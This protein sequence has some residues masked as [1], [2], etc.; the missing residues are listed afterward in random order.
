V[1]K[2]W[3]F[4]VGALAVLAACGGGGSEETAR[5]ETPA[6]VA[7]AGH[8]TVAGPTA[9]AG[10]ERELIVMLRANAQVT[11]V[12][13]RHG[14]V[15]LDR[16]GQRPIYRLQW[17]SAAAAD[18]AL[19]GLRADTE[20]RFAERNE[21]TD[22]PEARRQV[23]WAVRQVV[24][25]VGTPVESYRE[26]W[27]P[28]ALGL[29]AAHA[30]STGAGIR[31]AVLDTGADLQHPALAGRYARRADGSVLGFDFVDND[32]LPQEA[33]SS[34]DAGFGHG[35]HVAGLVALAAP[36]AQLMPVRVLDAAGRG[37]AWVLAEALMWAVDPDGNPAT[38]DGAHVINLSLG[39]TQPTRL[40]NTLVELATCSDDDDDEDDDDYSD[41]GFDDDKARCNLRGGV[42]V[43]AAAGNSGSASERQ[44]PAAEAAEGQLAVTALAQDARLAGFANRGSWVQLAAPGNQVI[45]TWPG[46]GYATLSGS[47]MA[48]PLA[49]GV[50]A[51]VLATKPDLKPVDVS[52][53]LAERSIAV[54][55]APGLRGLHALGA[56]A[57]FVPPDPSCPPR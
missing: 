36:S 13:A 19:N 5:A 52:K 23:V 2:R 42:V 39:T 20:V 38:D 6:S 15:V 53:R 49:S 30:Q 44:Y 32:A 11:A 45:S 31:V 17:P 51:L 4:S 25:A 28:L 12:A 10:T 33:G 56:V 21:L 18:A 46:G 50:A 40:L 34:A 41:P 54:C 9:V 37:N 57:D 47:S 43:M 8:A 48:T 55:D 35:T 3:L 14:G 7:S 26:Q 16:F 29:E 1:F 24:W 22:A 27:V